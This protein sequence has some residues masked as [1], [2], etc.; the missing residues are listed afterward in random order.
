MQ[1][2]QSPNFQFEPKNLLCEFFDYVADRW[3]VCEPNTNSIGK[4]HGNMMIS[5]I[6]ARTV[7]KKLTARQPI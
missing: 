2:I 1:K 7:G 6:L 5:V 4:C 3:F